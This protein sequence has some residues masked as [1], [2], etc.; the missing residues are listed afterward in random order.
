M[1]KV[2][3]KPLSVQIIR[4]GHEVKRGREREMEI[5]LLYTYL[6]EMHSQMEKA[7]AA[8]K[9]PMDGSLKIGR[10]LPF[11]LDG[12]IQ[13]EKKIESGRRESFFLLAS[14][15]PPPC[16]AMGCCCWS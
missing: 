5:C 3:G 4:L 16:V 2:G 1:G 6:P 7:Q 10:H 14:K 13:R 15:A 9:E 11:L 12:A 8:V